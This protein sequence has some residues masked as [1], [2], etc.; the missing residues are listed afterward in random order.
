MAKIELQNIAHSYNPQ[1]V[2]KTYAL[3]PFKEEKVEKVGLKVINLK[4]LVD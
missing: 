1:A 4:I 3:D 2:D